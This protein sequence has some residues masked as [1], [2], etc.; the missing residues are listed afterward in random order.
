[1]TKNRSKGIE[2]ITGLNISETGVGK[3][4]VR[5]IINRRHW[6]NG[7]SARIGNGVNID[8]RIEGAILPGM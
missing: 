1:M 6:K 5:R 7:S 3:E 8:G 2:G 4:A